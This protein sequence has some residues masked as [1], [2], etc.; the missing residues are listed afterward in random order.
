M[1]SRNKRSGLAA[2]SFLVLTVVVLVAAYQLQINDGNYWIGFVVIGVLIEMSYLMVHFLL[3]IILGSKLHVAKR[4]SQV[5][6]ALAAVLL[7]LITAILTI[8]IVQ[9]LRVIV[10]AQTLAIAGIVTLALALPTGF[11]WWRA[12]GFFKT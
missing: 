4:I 5:L 12:I 1:K 10:D 2:L 11:L 8:L 6:A 7:S 3:K 9:S